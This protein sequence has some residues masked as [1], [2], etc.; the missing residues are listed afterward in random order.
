MKLIDFSRTGDFVSTGD[1]MSIMAR[2]TKYTGI[3]RQG[4]PLCREEDGKKVRYLKKTG[5]VLPV[6]MPDRSKPE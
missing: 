2:Y 1:F 4:C 6:N 3:S 5:E